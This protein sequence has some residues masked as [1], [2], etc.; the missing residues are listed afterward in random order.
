MKTNLRERAEDLLNANPETQ[1]VLPTCDV[2][3]LIHELQMQNEEL[4]RA[5]SEL[6]TSRDAYA[7]LYDFAPVG[8]VTLDHNGAIQETNHMAAALFGVGRAN[9]M[10]RK[11]SDFLQRDAQ[12]AWFLQRR[13]LLMS[14]E[15]QTVELA[16]RREEDDAPFIARLEMRPLSGATPETWRVMVAVIDI[17]RQKSAEQALRN[18]LDNQERLIEQRTAELH[19]SEKRFKSLADLLPQPIWEADIEGCFS[20]ANRA[21]YE[22]FGYDP[23]DIEVGLNLAAVVAPEDRERLAEAVS[24]RLQGGEVSN[25]EYMHVRKDGSVF[26]GMVY[27]ALILTDGRPAGLRGITLDI[28]E[29]KESERIRDQQE[30]RLQRLAS[31][32]ATAQDDE[33]WRIAEGLHDDVAQLISACSVMLGVASKMDDA[34]KQ[35]ALIDDI[36]G[37]LREAG[38]KVRSLSFELA[39]ATLYRLGLRKALQELCESMNERYKTKFSISKGPSPE[40]LGDVTATALLRSARELLFN[41]VRHAAVQEARVSLALEG[42]CLLLAVEDSGRGFPLVEDGQSDTGEGLGLFSIETHLRGLGGE[43]QVESTPGEGARVTL[44]VPMGLQATNQGG[45]A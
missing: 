22:A 4:R 33:R 8:Y 14:D 41:V 12:D 36:D 2:Q 13:E 11:L 10:G 26:P 17:S 15:P 25:H 9:L 16:F 29:R 34:A 43:I 38:E 1:P 19:T 5:Q 23:E 37:F 44:R 31:K 6:A 24:T 40:H 20:Y 28:S 7:E 3:K 27:S 42:D 32:L 21:C 39:S 18:A 30:L 45:H 35:N